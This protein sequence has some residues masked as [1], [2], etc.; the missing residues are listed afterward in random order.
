MRPGDAGALMRLLRHDSAVV[1]ATLGSVVLIAWIYLLFGMRMDAHEAGAMLAPAVP[2]RWSAGYAAM[3]LLMWVLMMAAM[4]LPSAA[5]MILLHASMARRRRELGGWAA[6]SAIFVLGYI[7][8]WTLFSVLATALQWALTDAAQMSQAMSLSSRIT[9]AVTLIAAGAYQWTP[10]KQSCLRHCRSP[11]EFVLT[12]WRE[13]AW[14][15]FA[16]GLEHG[17]FCLG[18]CW[19]LMLLLFVGGVMNLLWIAGL[20]LFVIVEKAAPWGH[21]AGHMAGA[22]LVLWGCGA[23]LS[24]V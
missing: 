21:W 18:C 23:L 12:R 19:V 1:V 6:A 17:A 20:T 16:M 3:M 9:A 2:A 15:S 13:G 14:G 10:L 22:V 11:L 7:A 24:L 8:V 4:M 5:P